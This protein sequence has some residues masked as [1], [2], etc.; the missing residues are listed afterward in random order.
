MDLAT[1][2]SAEP[3]SATS[4]V[5]FITF[6]VYR[7][8]GTLGAKN[9]VIEV[10][11][12]ASAARFAP[13]GCVELLAGNV[14]YNA[15]SFLT[16]APADG[17]GL[18]MLYG[19]DALDETYAWRRKARDLDAEFAYAEIE[20]AV[21]H[22]EKGLVDR[23]GLRA[24]AGNVR[25]TNVRR[26]KASLQLDILAR[27]AG[28]VMREGGDPDVSMSC[29]A[30]MA[31]RPDLFTSTLRDDADL[32]QLDTLVMPVADNPAVPGQMRQV[33]LIRPSAQ[34]AGITQGSD[35]VRIVLP[36]WMNVRQQQ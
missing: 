3:P 23:A 4:T 6:A 30:Q 15:K 35:E 2:Y 16:L 14:P 17:E 5:R 34:V 21:G 7:R 20:I 8:T 28:Y 13:D 25:F 19:R 11:H 22:I 18:L 12:G 29:P 24:A 32:G 36:N 27:F 33:A 26:M 31:L 10:L 9:A 1:K